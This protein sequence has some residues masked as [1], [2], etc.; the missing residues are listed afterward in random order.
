M[1]RVLAVVL[2]LPTLAGGASLEHLGRRWD[3]YLGPRARPGRHL[4][5]LLFPDRPPRIVGRYGP[6]RVG[7]GSGA[8][9]AE[10][11]LTYLAQPA[12]RVVLLNSVYPSACLVYTVRPVRRR[13][14]YRGV[15]ELYDATCRVSIW[16]RRVTLVEQR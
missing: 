12:D 9:A 14:T 6:G 10:Q 7:T 13:L 1:I 4:E 5:T 3:A 11:S 15:L 8:H 2:L 16:R